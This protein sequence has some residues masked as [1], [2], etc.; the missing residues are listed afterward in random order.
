MNTRSNNTYIRRV[1]IA[2]S[3]LLIFIATPVAADLPPNAKCVNG[4][5][6]T[7]HYGAPGKGATWIPSR[8]KCEVADFAA[9]EEEKD[10]AEQKKAQTGFEGLIGKPGYS[11]QHPGTTK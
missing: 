7:P 3:G 6:V 8:T 10:I 9:M 2:L 11:W 5:V 1:L 4:M